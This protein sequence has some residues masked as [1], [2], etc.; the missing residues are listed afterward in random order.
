MQKFTFYASLF[1]FVISIY[2]ALYAIGVSSSGNSMLQI[3]P[4]LKVF[5]ILAGVLAGIAVY[6]GIKEAKSKSNKWK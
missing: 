5:G 4:W 2:L 6:L 1:Q 3:V